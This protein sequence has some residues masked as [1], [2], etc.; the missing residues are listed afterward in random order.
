[1]KEGLRFRSEDGRFGLTLEP[2]HVRALLRLAQR[3]GRQ[4]TGGVLAGYYSDALDCAHVTRVSPPPRD[5]KAGGARFERGTAGLR[6]WL[7]RLWTGPRMA[8]YLGEWH[9]HPHASPEPS[10]Q[11]CAQM[12][13]LAENEIARCPEPILLI[14]GG[15]PHG[16]WQVR[17]LVFLR[18]R[19]QVRLANPTGV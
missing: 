9:F 15:D 14:I 17:A 10:A 7:Q 19:Q 2:R 5:S 11:D 6:Q 4:E 18:G 1:M 8:Y 3:A 12:F 13:A 16:E